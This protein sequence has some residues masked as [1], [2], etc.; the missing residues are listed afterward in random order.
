VRLPE[1]VGEAPLED[2][3]AFVDQVTREIGKAG[4][5]TTTAHPFDTTSRPIALLAVICLSVAAGGVLLIT[6]LLTLTAGWRYGLVVAAWVVLAGL[7]AVGEKGISLVA[8]TAALIFPTNES[9]WEHLKLLFFPALLWW[10]AEWFFYGK[11]TPRF[12]AVKVW[13]LVTALAFIIVLYYTYVGV[14]GSDSLVIDIAIFELAVALYFRLSYLQFLKSRPET[15]G[16]NILA[17]IVF[18]TVLFSFLIFSFFPPSIG[19]FI[20]PKSE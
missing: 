15:E 10:I 4:F 2:G 6:S 9:V 14:V 16:E 8:L 3:L 18:L 11:K 1:T 13:S 7:V 20:P 19:L 17:S 12:F 5:T